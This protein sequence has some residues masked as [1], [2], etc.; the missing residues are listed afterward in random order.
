MGNHADRTNPAHLAYLDLALRAPWECRHRNPIGDLVRPWCDT[1]AC[2]ECRRGPA[3][4]WLTMM[5]VDPMY[6]P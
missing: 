3:S 6:L 4:A 2:P 1:P 5:G